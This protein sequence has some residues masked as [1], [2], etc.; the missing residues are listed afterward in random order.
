MKNVTGHDA[1]S[2]RHKTRYQLV[3]H[4]ANLAFGA[5]LTCELTRTRWGKV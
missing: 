2:S 5:R 3:T 1:T 4:R